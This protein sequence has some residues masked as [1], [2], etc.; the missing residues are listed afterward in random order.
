MNL[1]PIL[2]LFTGIDTAG[3]MFFIAVSVPIFAT[4]LY[5]KNSPLR[6]LE[7]YK[8]APVEEIPGGPLK[9]S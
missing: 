6:G 7:R 4:P 3:Y 9:T 1:L 5:F 8:G 2:F